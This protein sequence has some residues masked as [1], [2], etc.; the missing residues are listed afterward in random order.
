M[1]KCA[2]S[3]A[4]LRALPGL[5]DLLCAVPAF[6]TLRAEY[7]EAHITLVGL[8]S[9]RWFVER[10]SVYVDDLLVVTS[11]PGLPETPGSA[12]EALAFLTSAQRRRFGLA[13][14]LH[15]SGPV[16]NV[17][18]GLLGADHQVGTSLPGQTRPENG[19]FIDYPG[20]MAEIHRLLA[21]LQHL[22]IATRG[23]HL[24]WPQC[25]GDR[26]APN[27]P[28]PYAVIHAGA[29]R[30]DR[31]WSAKG[32]A[33]VAIELQRRGLHIVLT[34]GSDEAATTKVVHREIER[35]AASAVPSRR[36]TVVDL[37]GRTSL[38]QLA[39][40]LAG[41]RLTITNDTGVSHLAAAVAAPSVVVFTTSDPQRWAPLDQ[42]RHI[43]ADL[44]G[45]TSDAGAA[46]DAGAELTIM[47][48][49]VDR[50]LGSA[51]SGAREQRTGARVQRRVAP[52][53]GRG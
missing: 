23:D 8:Q 6:R 45:G 38:D 10:F 11:F 12:A 13:I 18:L 24:E 9:A 22:G 49:A 42:T 15:G 32:F 34:G 28:R 29:S 5:G 21:P 3:V 41:T 48:D 1:P 20:D 43:R 40:L 37:A 17:L 25:A 47:L 16:S 30:P 14:G 50:A 33:A 46:P 53:V 52:Q 44:R 26:P 7:P 2:T 31:Q 27:V 4:V 36:S 51:R 19:T 35:G 39:D